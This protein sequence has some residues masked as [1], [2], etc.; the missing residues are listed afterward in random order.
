M[1]ADAQ[2]APS[3]VSGREPPARGMTLPIF[4]VSLCTSVSPETSPDP[5]GP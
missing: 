2:L 3:L 4:R 5:V 1:K